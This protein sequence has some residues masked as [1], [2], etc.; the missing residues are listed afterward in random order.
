MIFN[1]QLRHIGLL[2][3]CYDAILS[4]KEGNDM[5]NVTV[6]V[7]SR[8][9]HFKGDT[10][11]V[12]AVALHSE[13]LEKMVIYKHKGEVWARPIFSFLSLEDVSAREDNVTGQKY[14]FEKIMEK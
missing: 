8:W 2:L 14:R 1:I 4:K 9:K 11:E 10:M 7:G 12:I 5:Q 6:E 13:N 3:L